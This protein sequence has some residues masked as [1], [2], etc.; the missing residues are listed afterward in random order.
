MLVSITRLRLVRWTK[1]FKFFALSSPAID[2]AI[3]DPDC[4]AGATYSGPGL[5]FWTATLWKDEASMR[6]YVQSGAHQATLPWLSRICSEGAT[7]HYKTDKRELPQRS[8]VVK[9]LA[10]SPKFFRVEK[11]SA[12]HEAKTI[13]NI[14][15][16]LTRQFK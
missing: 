3:Q 9:K 4:L 13:P 14:P 2:Q 10:Q 1:I 6:M 12:A 15:P 11:P 7:T 16:K 5:T 8:E